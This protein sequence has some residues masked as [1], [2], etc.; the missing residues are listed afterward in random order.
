MERAV[1]RYSLLFTLPSH[2]K[3]VAYLCIQCFATGIIARLPLYSSPQ[4]FALGLALG[5]LLFATTLV[6]NYVTSNIILRKDL[7]LGPRRCSFISL[8]SNLIVTGFVC[9]AVL[10]SSWLS[11]IS[12]WSKVMAIG[13]FATMSLSF[14]VFSVLSFMNPSRILLA[15]ALQP[16]LFLAP[17]LISYVPF[18]I[19]GY[20]VLY[21]FLAV[22]AAFF[23][24]Q[25][26]TA[27][28]NTLGTRALGIPSV[29]MFKAFLANWTEGLEK[30]FE[31][32]LEQL[33]EERNITVSLIAFKTGDKLKAV[34][35]VP[36]VHPGPFKNIGSSAIPGL[37]QTALE[38]KLECIVSVPHGIS[39]HELDLAS[40]AQNQRL[41]EQII[42]VAKFDVF[43]TEATPFVTTKVEGATAGCQI[44]GDCALITFTLA[45]ETMEDLPLELNEAI[46]KEAKQKGLSWAVAIDTHNSIQGPFDAEK[47]I[48]PIKKASKAIIEHASDCEQ[49]RF[50]VGAAKTVPADLSIKEGLGPSGITV[51]VV[52]TNDVANAYVTVD[53]NN[54]VSGLRE[55]ILASLLELGISSGEVL[56]TDTHIV[57][58]IVMNERGYHPVGEAIDHQ[59][60]IE[61][62]NKAAT[63]ALGNLEPAET[64]WRREIIQDIKVIGEKHIDK[65]SLIVD[66]GAKRA[67]KTSTVIF[68]ATGLVLA[69]L[70]FLLR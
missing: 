34:M 59:R 38:K 15:S 21:V 63:Q 67:K 27:D 47:I 70:L 19:L 53:G 46:L 41:I 54:M 69:I 57:N 32:I 9:V 23:S 31:D 4:G 64:S 56:T 60:L 11:D 33:G 49:S 18:E 50:E 3:I 39:G 24:V 45:P 66:E 16:A 68:P 2:T 61:D 13:F 26:F 48:E 44:F 14:L 43:D 65:L 36:T 62:I 30:P 51:I 35:V 55:K 29:R 52:K 7:I 37:I 8:I 28:L 25:I 5:G 58:A 20:S 40:Q 22:L 42:K 1:S 12:V 17:L 6:A 10:V